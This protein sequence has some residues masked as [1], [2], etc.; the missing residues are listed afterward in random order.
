MEHFVAQ[1]AG[2]RVVK[3]KIVLLNQSFIKVLWVV[4]PPPAVV[5]GIERGTQVHVSV[6]QLVEH[7][8]AQVEEI[9]GLH[10][11]RIYTCAVT[12]AGLLP[13]Y[14]FFVEEAVMLVDNGP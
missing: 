4:A 9:G 12:L 11:F 1:R 14:A 3:L 7:L 8:P 13:V 6:A 2:L 10:F 5:R